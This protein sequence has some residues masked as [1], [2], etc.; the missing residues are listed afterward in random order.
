MPD[1]GCVVVTP[2]NPHALAV[3]PLVLRDSV[4]LSASAR[5]RT[6]GN[7]DAAVGVFADGE[8]VL[9]LK[10]GGTVEIR[11][12]KKTARLVELEGYDPYDVLARK[13]GWTGSSVKP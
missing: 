2:S 8:R 5:A 10:A 11:K 9:E 13:L 6:D 3:R 12:S 4:R 7:G 1:S